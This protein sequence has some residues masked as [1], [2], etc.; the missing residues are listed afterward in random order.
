MVRP[1][2]SPQQHTF[3]IRQPKEALHVRPKTHAASYR[4]A[5]GAVKFYLGTHET[6]WLARLDVP[7][8]ISHRR[9]AKRRGL[10]RACCDWALDS[11]GF[12]EL[13]LHGAW[14]TSISE[15]VEAVARYSEQ[16]GRLEWAAPMDWMCEPSM[17]A[18]TGL[19]V[20]EHQERTVANYLDLRGQ[21]PFIP[22]LQGWTVSEYE[23]CI[24]LYR[25]AGVDLG[26]ESLVGVGSVCRRQR[27]VEIAQI[28]RALNDAGI[29]THGFGVKKEG[30][31]R[32]GR[33]LSSAD[34]MAWS[35]AARRRWPLPG[36]SH[37][38][39]TNCP[40]FALRWRDEVL[41]RTDWLQF[42]L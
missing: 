8:F 34:S 1:E 7:L 14:R 23:R 41:A 4:H 24:E 28:M 17:L 10:P 32:Y 29:R 16:I 30:V 38:R 11:G 12:T 39:C 22:V 18:T 27:T 21:G 31:S 33:L 9:L 15:Y 6:S 25:S 13:V 37:Q 20:R 2:T 3:H 36:C 5:R 40:R 19:S 42:E 26:F 35:Y